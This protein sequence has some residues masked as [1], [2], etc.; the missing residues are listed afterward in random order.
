MKKQKVT[1]SRTRD[2]LS[3]TLSPPVLFLLQ[4]CLHAQGGMGYGAETL[5]AYQLTSLTA[6]AVGLV[7]NA[8]QRCLQ[9]LNELQLP[10][11][12]PAC[13]FL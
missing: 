3:E 5:L 13:L 9:V 8:N 11:R 2:L 6:Y 4:L 10:L 12:E 7:L 1:D